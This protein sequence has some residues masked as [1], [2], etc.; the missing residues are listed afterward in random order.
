MARFT[1]LDML[2]CSFLDFGTGWIIAAIYIFD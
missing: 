1:F 2:S